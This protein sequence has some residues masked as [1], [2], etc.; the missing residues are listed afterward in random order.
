MPPKTVKVPSA[1]AAKQ[2]V[3]K[4]LR[5]FLDESEW[6]ELLSITPQDVRL[7]TEAEMGR[8]ENATEYVGERLDKM[9]G[10]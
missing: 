3:A 10:K 5:T 2:M 8:L 7:F 4:A 1:G 9:A 6:A